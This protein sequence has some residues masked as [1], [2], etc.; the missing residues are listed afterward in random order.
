[1]A[2]QS[3][4]ALL[5]NAVTLTLKCVRHLQISERKVL[6]K[7][8]MWSVHK[9]HLLLRAHWTLH[10]YSAF[11]T[12]IISP[13]LATRCISFLYLFTAL[14]CIKAKHSIFWIVPFFLPAVSLTWQVLQ[15]CYGKV[16]LQHGGKSRFLR[17]LLTSL[18]RAHRKSLFA[19]SPWLQISGNVVGHNSLPSAAEPSSSATCSCEL[20][21]SMMHPGV[22]HSFEIKAPKQEIP[23]VLPISTPVHQG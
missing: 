4:L 22:W 17:F 16:S 23:S 15:F 2:F 8:E 13:S 20:C 1:M 5:A 7:L 6:G 21:E 11:E 18:A 9:Y 14:L 10:H 3:W 19:V 12:C